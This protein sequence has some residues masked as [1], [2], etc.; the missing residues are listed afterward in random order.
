MHLHIDAHERQ[1]TVVL[2][3][4]LRAADIREATLALVAHPSFHPH[5]PTL[6]DL[7]EARAGDVT[8]DEIRSLTSDNESWLG[9]AER[10]VALLVAR[11]VDYGVMRMWTALAEG[12]LPARRRVFR[13][14]EEASRWLQ[15]D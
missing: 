1:A 3:G 12:P 9:A 13:D 4:P 11:D 2:H 6:W 14:L 15:G 8:M 10:R 7:R 5:L